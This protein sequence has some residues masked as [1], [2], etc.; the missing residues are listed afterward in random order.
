MNLNQLRYFVS[1]AESGSFTKGAR[2]L[3]ISH[4]TTSRAI[5]ALEEELGRRLLDRDNRVL[6]LTAAGELML[7]E[8]KN[9][10]ASVDGLG[11]RLRSLSPEAER[12]V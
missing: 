10:I 1:V 11:E 12:Q 4:S 2:R 3:Y 7:V 8:A 9:I 6:G 5:S